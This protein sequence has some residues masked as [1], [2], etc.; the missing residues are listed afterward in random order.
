MKNIILFRLICNYIYIT[1]NFYTN[2][3]NIKIGLIKSIIFY[4]I[5]MSYMTFYFSL[6][7]EHG[8]FDIEK[9]KFE[10]SIKAY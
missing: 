5:L 1:Y 2:R 3:S 4:T 10:V 8:T 6:Y 7:D 9:T